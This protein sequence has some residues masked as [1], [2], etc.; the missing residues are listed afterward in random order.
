M[1]SGPAGKKRF[2]IKR[3][4]ANRPGLTAKTGLESTFEVYM[5]KYQCPQHAI[6]DNPTVQEPAPTSHAG[7]IQNQKKEP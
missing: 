3:K 2:T 1:H 4:V 6:V 7:L 5:A